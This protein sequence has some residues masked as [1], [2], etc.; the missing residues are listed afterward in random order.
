MINR[1]AKSPIPQQGCRGAP[2]RHT[3]P[4]IIKSYLQRYVDSV[5]S[6]LLPWS[7]S[8]QHGTCSHLDTGRTPKFPELLGLLILGVQ[9]ISEDWV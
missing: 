3:T 5:N 8:E 9:V 6:L 4:Q 7:L 1:L 2:G